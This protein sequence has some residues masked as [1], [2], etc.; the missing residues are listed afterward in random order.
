MVPKALE[1]PGKLG[2][3]LEVKEEKQRKKHW[4]NDVQTLPLRHP[5]SS[6]ARSME[7][8]NKEKQHTFLL[9]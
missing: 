5:A 4:S 3:A 9:D 1:V 2:R 6:P 7:Q 8:N